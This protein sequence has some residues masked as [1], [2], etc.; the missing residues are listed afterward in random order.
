MCIEKDFCYKIKQYYS[1]WCFFDD[2]VTAEFRGERCYEKILD[3]VVYSKKISDQRFYIIRVSAKC[4]IILC[5]LF[6]K[7]FIW[8]G[9]FKKNEGCDICSK[10]IEIINRN[11]NLKRSFFDDCLKAY[12]NKCKYVI[13]FVVFN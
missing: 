4:F 11:N 7:K 12:I 5:D 3:I 1:C 13:P 6:M 9:T 8:F 10:N 2:L